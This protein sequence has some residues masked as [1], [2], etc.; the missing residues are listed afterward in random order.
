VSAC[1]IAPSRPAIRSSPPRLRRRISRA[2]ATA[3]P[4][5]R[6]L[7][8]LR[9]R[10][11]ELAEE[12]RGQGIATLDQVRWAIAEASGAVSFIQDG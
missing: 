9:M 2:R 7:R 5:A 6:N 8:R 1:R 10:T 11:D 12:A 3:P 4:V